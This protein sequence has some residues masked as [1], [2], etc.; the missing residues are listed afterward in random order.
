[1]KIF[2]FDV[3]SL[4]TQ[5]VRYIV[6]S[7]K[8]ISTFSDYFP[9]FTSYSAEDRELRSLTIIK[10]P[11]LGFHF[12][13]GYKFFITNIEGRGGLNSLSSSDRILIYINSS[14][15]KIGNMEILIPKLNFLGLRKT[16]HMYC[17]PKGLADNR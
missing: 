5:E 17:C 11:N 7:Y 8:F 2:G 9:T 13:E 14:K 4:L 6:T 3:S 15:I 1:M 10:P 16:S 12:N